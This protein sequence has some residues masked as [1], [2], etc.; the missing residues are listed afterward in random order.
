M[1]VM[2]CIT[3]GNKL[4]QPIP[5]YRISSW[6]WADGSSW[7]KEIPILKNAGHQVIAVQLAEHSLADDPGVQSTFTQQILLPFF[8]ILITYYR[9]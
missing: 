8:N 2:K 5:K 1:T 7:S 6:A 4:S 9:Q 3:L